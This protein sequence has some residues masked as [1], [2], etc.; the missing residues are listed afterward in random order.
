MKSVMQKV[1]CSVALTAA[2]A[3]PLREANERDAGDPHDALDARDVVDARGPAFDVPD[4]LTDPTPRLVLPLPGSVIPPSEHAADTSRVILAAWS[5]GAARYQLEVCRDFDRDTESCRSGLWTSTHTAREARL[6]INGRGAWYWRVCSISGED[7]ARP[8]AAAGCSS[9]PTSPWWDLWLVGGPTETASAHVILGTD[10]R[11][12]TRPARRRLDF[13]GDGTEDL[14]GLP[15]PRHIVVSLSADASVQIQTEAPVRDFP[16]GTRTPMAW[17]MPDITGDR[18]AEVIFVTDSDQNGPALWYVEGGTTARPPRR[19]TLHGVSPGAIDVTDVASVGEINA[20]GLADLAVS[21]TS[22]E[23][24][25]LFFLSS[26]RGNIGSYNSDERLGRPVC[27]GD[28]TVSADLRI[29]RGQ[30]TDP[31]RVLVLCRNSTGIVHRVE[32]HDHAH[33]SAAVLAS[34]NTPFGVSGG[35]RDVRVLGD[36]TGDQIDDLLLIVPGGAMVARG[37]SGDNWLSASER[38]T[39]S[40]FCTDS[41]SPPVT[42]TGYLN[43]DALADLVM[44][45]RPACVSSSENLGRWHFSARI[46]RPDGA[47]FDVM[48]L[49]NAESGTPLLPPLTQRP[50]LAWRDFRGDG[51]FE[52]FVQNGAMARV[53]D[54]GLR[55]PVVTVGP[56]RLGPSVEMPQRRDDPLPEESYQ[57]TENARSQSIY[58]TE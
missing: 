50:S 44:V 10:A 15:D 30:G 18:R 8:D 2:C 57:T 39:V 51:R 5:G 31:N 34:S 28:S 32:L 54:L 14:V 40:N 9:R 46:G 56:G 16:D 52:L 55:T 13:I 58:D 42:V 1:A 7:A 17:L 48:E 3:A 35:L 41:E 38:V 33:T 23:D 11:P 21:A 47:L 24:P 22:R 25:L 37:A 12:A 53:Y 49:N 20:D 4:A 27:H 29:I 6:E 45:S 19:I 43:D 36:V 26:D